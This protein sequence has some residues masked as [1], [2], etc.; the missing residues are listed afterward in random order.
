MRSLPNMVA[1]APGDAREAEQM[2]FAMARRAT[3]LVYDC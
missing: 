1:L 2:A 3:K